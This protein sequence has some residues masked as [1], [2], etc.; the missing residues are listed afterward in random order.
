MPEVLGL[1]R[2]VDAQQRSEDALVGP[3][4]DL[5]PDEIGGRRSGKPGDVEQ[6][7][8]REPER[9]RR[10][11]LGGTA[12]GARP[13]R[14]GSTD[15]SAR[16]SRR[17]RP[18]RRAAPGPW[19]PSPRDEP[20]PYSLPAM[21]TSGTPFGLVAHGGV[22]DRRLLT[23]GQ[24]HGHAALGIG[25]EVVADAWVGEGSPDHHLVI[26]ASRAIGVELRR[27]ARRGSAARGRPGS[28]AGSIPPA[29]CGRS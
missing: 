27:P 13:C 12:A 15:G 1:A 11:R 18:G 6:F 16:S 23:V 21:T 20:E 28:T 3:H 19:P 29:R 22:E 10:S 25:H 2:G 4:G 9:R 24:V 8:S 14:S 5:A 17:S 7:P 26:A